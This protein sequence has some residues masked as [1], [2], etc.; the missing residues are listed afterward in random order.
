MSELDSLK[1]WTAK[2]YD[3]LLRYGI[4]FDAPGRFKL[5]WRCEIYMRSIGSVHFFPVPRATGIH[6]NDPTEAIRA[7]LIQAETKLTI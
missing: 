3:V 5:E 1:Q 7:A 4:E 2:G 6:P